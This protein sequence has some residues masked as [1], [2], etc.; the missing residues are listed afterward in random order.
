MESLKPTYPILSSCSTNASTAPSTMH[1]DVCVVYTTSPST[2]PPRLHHL[3]VCTTSPSTPPHVFHSSDKASNC[4]HASTDCY[5]AIIA[6]AC[7]L[8]LLVRVNA[9]GL[10]GRIQQLTQCRLDS[11]A[12]AA[13]AA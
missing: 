4:T 2:P 11:S 7:W 6:I 9:L 10:A 13:A 12:A 8:P 1:G 5:S 3:P